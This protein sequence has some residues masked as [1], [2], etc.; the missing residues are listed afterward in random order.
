MKQHKQ[1]SH[2]CLGQA[3]ASQ[4]SLVAQGHAGGGVLVQ[5]VGDLC[6]DGGLGIHV[7]CVGQLH[8]LSLVSQD[9]SDLRSKSL[10]KHMYTF[11][12]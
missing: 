1:E 10:H 8:G 3:S 11:A 2:A 7:L 9:G 4:T 12:S 6:S 5:L